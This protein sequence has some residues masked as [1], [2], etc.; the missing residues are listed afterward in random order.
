MT[1]K[2][3]WKAFEQWRGDPT[4]TI[5]HGDCFEEIRRLKPNS[6]DSVV[7]DPPAGI[8]FMGKEWDGDRGGRDEW[9]KWLTSL[10]MET[11]RVLKPGAYMFVWAI[12]RTSH[13]TA[14][15]IEEAGFEIRDIVTHLFGSGFPKSLDVSKAL[16][17]EA[18]LKPKFVRK[19]KNGCGNTDRSI[20]KAEGLARSREKEFLITAPVSRDA[21]KWRGWGTALK[22]ASEHWILCRKPI[23]ARTVASNVRRHG[24]GAINIKDSRVG[25]RWPANVILEDE[26]L[27]DESRFFYVAKPSPAEKNEG[28]GSAIENRHPTVKPLKLM[29]YLIKLITPEGGTVLDMFAGS[30]TTIK[31]AKNLG[32]SAV[33]I[34]KEAEYCRIARYRL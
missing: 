18:N 17:A 11:S 31:A 20:H 23:A 5:I 25:E 16:D 22:P 26:M 13:W 12:P 28:R 24:T 2:P 27:G 1:S 9:I 29:E 15:A 32:F 8:S 19:S 14:M 33:G 4:H 21:I 10:F 7:T 3:K 30:G 34:E 6:I